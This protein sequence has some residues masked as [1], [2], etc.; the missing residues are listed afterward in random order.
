M[1]PHVGARIRRALPLVKERAK[2]AVELADQLAFVLKTRPLELDERTRGRLSE[3]TRQRLTR[4]RDA[5]EQEPEF[6]AAALEGRLKAFAAAEGV[7]MGKFGPALRGVLAGGAPAPD[8]A[9][10]LAA[11]GREEALARLNDALASPI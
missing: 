3:E 11:L 1:D 5:L 9:A 7:G 2:T 10:T 4:L 6:T 8:L